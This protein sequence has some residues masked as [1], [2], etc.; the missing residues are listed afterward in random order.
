MT[1]RNTYTLLVGLF[2]LV[3]LLAA[4]LVPTDHATALGKV[5]CG[6]NGAV[7]VANL[8]PIVDHNGEGSMHEHQI[9]GNTA[10]VDQGDAA[11]YADLQ[12]GSTDCRVPAD[13]AG[14]WTP[15]LR[16]V[17]GPK[18]GQ[19]IPAQQ[20]TAYYR[21]FTNVGKFGE[22]AA[23]PADTRLVAP[24][25][26]NMWSCGQNS[27]AKSALVPAI[28]DCTGQSGKPGHTLT[29]HV[30]FPSCWDGVLPDHH[31]SDVGDTSDNEHYAYPVRK[32]C[33]AGFPHK[34]VGLNETVQFEYVGNGTDV[35]LSSDEMMGTSDGLSMHG[36]FLNAWNQP[37]FEAFVKQCVQGV[38]YTN[39]ACMP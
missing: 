20:F 18:S 31:D 24:I 8:D 13:T 15:T 7:T 19:L 9:F 5:K 14:Y 21:P 33:P 11:N 1:R 4:L 22:G 30:K 3:V 16:Y 23:F 37:E 25:G 28:P 32:A 36:D 35:A 34:M 2:G 38:G 27:G 17:S 26:H 6:D 10:W 39:A 29:A 12:G